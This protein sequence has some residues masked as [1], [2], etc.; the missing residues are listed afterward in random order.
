MIWY[1]QKIFGKL[2]NDSKEAFGNSQK[3]MVSPKLQKVKTNYEFALSSFQRGAEKVLQGYVQND[4]RMM[5]KGLE[6]LEK[7]A[8]F[9][10]LADQ[11]LNVTPAGYNSVSV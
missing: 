6:R 4:L 5:I 11:E 9:M 2:T 3:H 7:G 8:E 1:P 10:R